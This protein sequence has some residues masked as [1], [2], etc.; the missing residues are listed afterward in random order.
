LQIILNDF[1][2]PRSQKRVKEVENEHV[3]AA[4][5]AAVA[6]RVSL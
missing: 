6:G 2:Q 3:T 5:A 1:W 4:A